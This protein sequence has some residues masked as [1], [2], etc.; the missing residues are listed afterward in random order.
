MFFS[1]MRIIPAIDIIEGKCV[2][3]TQGDYSKKKVYNERPLEVAK[4]FEDAGLRYIHVVDLDGAKAGEVR[5]WKAIETICEKTALQIDFGGGVKKEEDIK[6][7]L[8]LGVT[9]INIGSLAIKSPEIVYDWISQFGPGA[10]I[11]SADVRNRLVAIH[12][13]QSESGVTI[14]SLIEQFLLHQLKFVTCTDIS[15]DGM[16]KGP[17]FDLYKELMLRFPDIN[18]VASGGVSNLKDIQTLHKMNMYGVIVG[19]AIYEGTIELKELMQ[20]Q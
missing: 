7:L 2:R 16:L 1:Y 17:N 4:Q 15:K 9:Q 11:L 14:N 19:K 5:N 20:F 18:L 8:N 6:G 12:G 3:L 13:W 10:I